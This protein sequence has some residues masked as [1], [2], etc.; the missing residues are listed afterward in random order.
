MP[1]FDCLF[2]LLYSYVN[3]QTYRSRTE[4]KE[5]LYA[6]LEV[7]AR[8]GYK[9]TN[10]GLIAASCGLSR[11]TVYQ[12]F[13]DKSE[14][15]HFAVKNTTDSMLEKYSS[16]KWTS[17]EDPVEKLNLLMVDILNTADEHQRE[18]VNL[19][20]VLKDIEGDLHE[21]IKRRTVKLSLLLSRIIRD[22][23][24]RNPNNLN[25]NLKPQ[26]EAQKL[27]VLIESYCFQT[28]YIP[29]NKETVRELI[30]DRISSYKA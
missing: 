12:Y 10:L 29:Q 15:F 30:T 17:I 8:E 26:Q 2:F 4:K 1:T 5:I 23:L 14:I 19:I 18:I 6:S 22:C 28:A 20:I 25:K 24:K 16:Q 11:T 9:D 7:F 21:T 3:A 13:K 27:I